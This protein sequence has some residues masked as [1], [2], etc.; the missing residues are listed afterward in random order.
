MKHWF[1]HFI[2]RVLGLT[3]TFFIL[4]YALSGDGSSDAMGNGMATAFALVLAF[5]ITFIGGIIFLSVE[6]TNL[7]KF[8][9]VTKA[10]CNMIIIGLMLLPPILL[11]ALE[12]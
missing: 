10:R 9:A 4:L 6:I 2:F 8:G 1:F 7:R 11:I 3:V 5:A 12:A